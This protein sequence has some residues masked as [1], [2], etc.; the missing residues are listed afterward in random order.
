MAPLYTTPGELLPRSGRCPQCGHHSQWGEVIRS[1]YAR[2]EGHERE[3]EQAKKEELRV[4]RRAR[5]KGRGGVTEEVSDQSGLAL[6]SLSL[7]SP[8]K[9][10]RRGQR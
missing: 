10:A 7:E 2:K 1:C 9:R 8:T 4:T 5:R 6:E 3:K